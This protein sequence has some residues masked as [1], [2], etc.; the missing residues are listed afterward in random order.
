VCGRSLSGLLLPSGTGFDGRDGES[1]NL[2]DSGYGK[3]Y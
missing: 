3:C 1:Y 2:I